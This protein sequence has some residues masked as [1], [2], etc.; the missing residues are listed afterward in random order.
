MTALPDTS[1]IWHIGSYVIIA[2]AL[3]S[4]YASLQLLKP[5]MSTGI[6]DPGDYWVVATIIE[7][8][9]LLIAGAAGA[10]SKG[11]VFTKYEPLKLAVAIGSSYSLVWIFIYVTSLGWDSYHF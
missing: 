5:I 4:L 8:S 7:A 10:V 3:V 9:L 2:I 11:K 6:S 1:R